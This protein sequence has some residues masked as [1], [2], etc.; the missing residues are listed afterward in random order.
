MEVASVSS[1]FRWGLFFS[2]AQFTD[3][4]TSTWR[5]YLQRLGCSFPHDYSDSHS[6]PPTRYH[7]QCLRLQFLPDSCREDVLITMIGELVTT[8]MVAPI[9]ATGYVECI[10]AWSLASHTGLGSSSRPLGCDVG[11]ILLPKKNQLY[12]CFPSQAFRLFASDSLSS[13]QQL[14]V[15]F[16]HPFLHLV[17][18]S[19]LDFFNGPHALL[20]RQLLYCSF[21]DIVE[22]P[23]GA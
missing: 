10:P 15:A 19:T 1:I 22:L 9:H 4:N 2:L 12:G 8:W 7:L 16:Q 3:S 14:N 5:W 21:P 6:Y 23:H 18:L 20:F 13:L 17:T 11:K